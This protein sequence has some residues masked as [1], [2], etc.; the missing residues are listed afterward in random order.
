MTYVV[1]ADGAGQAL[2]IDPV[3]DF[4]PKN[5]RTAWEAAGAMA[6]YLD[7]Q[8]L[9]VPYVV[10]THAHADHLS[11]MPFFNVSATGRGP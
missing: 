4:D 8:R 7:A 2:V 5:G 3:R 1:H 11:G 6:R 10:D 9:Q